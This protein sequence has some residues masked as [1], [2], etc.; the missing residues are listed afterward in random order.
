M[1]D[2]LAVASSTGIWIYDV[3]NGEELDLFTG[4]TPSINCVSI[5]RT[6]RLIRD[7]KNYVIHIRGYF[8]G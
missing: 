8:S 1:V 7:N 4:H 6:R 5:I 3:H 2:G